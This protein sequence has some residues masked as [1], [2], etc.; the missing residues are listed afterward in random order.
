MNLDVERIEKSDFLVKA[1]E[2]NLG[3]PCAFLSSMLHSDRLP[4]AVE[5]RFPK[6]IIDSMLAL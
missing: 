2:K 5:A 6:T 3:S 1:P 4:I